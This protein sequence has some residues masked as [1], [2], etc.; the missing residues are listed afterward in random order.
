LRFTRKGLNV[1]KVRLALS[2][3]ARLAYESFYEAIG[4]FYLWAIDSSIV[5]EMEK[6]KFARNLNPLDLKKVKIT[7]ELREKIKI[8]NQFLC[9]LCG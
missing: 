9:G 8:K 4:P 3:L 6:L 5:M 2:R 1:R 7:T